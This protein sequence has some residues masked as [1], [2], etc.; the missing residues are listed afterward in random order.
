MGGGDEFE[1]RI[2]FDLKGE[3]AKWLKW[4]KEQGYVSSYAEAIR[5]SLVL[6]RDYYRK[7]GI[8]LK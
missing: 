4:L 7:L 1:E 8:T 5:F 2:N 3:L 6:L